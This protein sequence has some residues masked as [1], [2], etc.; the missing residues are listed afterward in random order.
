MQGDV[1]VIPSYWTLT[2][3]VNEVTFAIWPHNNLCLLN[4]LIHV[5]FRIKFL[6]YSNK[7]TSL[8][9]DARLG[10]TTEQDIGTVLSERQC[11]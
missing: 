11:R 6:L 1:W 8:Y 10:S 3:A 2:R 4:G 7:D 9:A 5:K